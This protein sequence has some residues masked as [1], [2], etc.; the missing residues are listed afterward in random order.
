MNTFSKFFL[1]IFGIFIGLAGVL[2]LQNIAFELL[3]AADDGLFYLGIFYLAIVI[4]IWGS[5]V[6]LATVYFKKLIGKEDSVE[7]EQ[8]TSNEQKPNN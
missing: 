8:Q 5:S 7:S 2:Q 6:Y 3:S 1:L 4:F